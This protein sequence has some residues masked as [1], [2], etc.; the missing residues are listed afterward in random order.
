MDAADADDVV[1]DGAVATTSGTHRARTHARSGKR[2]KKR[3]KKSAGSHSPRRKHNTSKPKK[4]HRRHHHSSRRCRSPSA[5]RPSRSESPPQVEVGGGCNAGPSVAAPAS[6]PRQEKCALW[7]KG[8]GKAPSK[9]GK[10]KQPLKRHRDRSSSSSRDG[11]VI[12]LGSWTDRSTSSGSWFSVSGSGRD[13]DGTSSTSS[14][15]AS[16]GFGAGRRH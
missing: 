16:R 13:T 3:A 6:R 15:G 11:S 4:S 8:G 5:R 12:L 1:E 7:G 10:G 2:E 9:S 14:L